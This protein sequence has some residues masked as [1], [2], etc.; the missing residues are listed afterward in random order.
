MAHRGTDAESKVQN[1]YDLRIRLYR[2][3]A[4][5]RQTSTRRQ[6]L[7][8]VRDVEV[9]RT[10]CREEADGLPVPCRVLDNIVG[11]LAKEICRQAAVR[12]LAKRRR[13]L[14]RAE[15]VTPPGSQE[16]VQQAK[17]E[18]WRTCERHRRDVIETVV[19]YSAYPGPSHPREQKL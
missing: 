17:G 10:V 7:T 4:M 5:Q 15:T 6:G 12:E 8:P 14:L 19:H 2:H 3:K 9:S 13:E 18:P 1:L 11:D 16:V